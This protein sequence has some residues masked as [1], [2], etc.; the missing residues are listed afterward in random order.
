MTAHSWARVFIQHHVNRHT[1]YFCTIILYVL[2]QCVHSTHENT[3]YRCIFPSAQCESKGWFDSFSHKQEPTSSNPNGRIEIRA[4]N[5]DPQPKREAHFRRSSCTWCG[6]ICRA[7]PYEGMGGGR[8]EVRKRGEGR[9]GKEERGRKREQKSNVHNYTFIAA[10]RFAALLLSRHVAIVPPCNLPDH[11]WRTFRRALHSDHK[12]NL[13]TGK[14][15]PHRHKYPHRISTLNKTSLFFLPFKF[16]PCI[17]W[18]DGY[19]WIRCVLWFDGYDWARCISWFDG[20]DWIRCILW[21][22]GYDWV[23]CILRFCHD[24]CFFPLLNEEK[25]L[26]MQGCHLTLPDSFWLIDGQVGWVFRGELRRAGGP[27]CP[28]YPG[29]AAECGGVFSQ[30]L[31]GGAG[32][33]ESDRQRD[34]L[35]R[36]G[37]AA[38]GWSERRL[39]PQ[40]RVD[41]VCVLFSGPSPG[42]TFQVT[43]ELVDKCQKCKNVDRC[44]G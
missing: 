30:R 18:F 25:S 3:I 26:R 9:E 2:M 36:D 20:Y 31:L 35:G 11:P 33:T 1:T 44:N 24:L 29:E 14:A 27:Q 37:P 32:L 22:D 34:G 16:T 40:Y 38:G 28:E 4:G 12:C 5:I 21:F 39:H 41:F 8:K 15:P 23:R 42:R 43:L 17:P 19:D 10:H 13:P 6:V 7:V